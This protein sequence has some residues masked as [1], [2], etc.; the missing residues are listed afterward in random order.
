MRPL[1]RALTVLL[2][3]P[4]LLAAAC[5]EKL[6]ATPYVMRNESA[7]TTYAA[8]DPT[9]RTPEMQVLYVT[10]RTPTPNDKPG[11]RYGHGR[12]DVVAYGVATVEL[13]P[14]PSWEELVDLS[15]RGDRDREYELK[16]SDVEQKGT[17]T[18]VTDLMEVRGDRLAGR[19]GARAQL[20]AEAGAFGAQ[21]SEWLA[22]TDRK[23]VVV[24]IHGFNNTFDDAVIRLAQAWHFTGRQGVPIVY[25]WPA[26]FGGLSGYAYDRESGEFT[27]VHL[28]L[29]IRA[30]A[31][32]PDVQKIHIVSHSRGTDVATTAL[33]E[34]NAE[35]RGMSGLSLMTTLLPPN[36]ENGGVSRAEFP[37]AAEVF[38]IGTLVLAAPDLDVDV[39]RQRFYAENLVGIAE[40]IIVY[41]SR[42]DEALSWANW[43]FSGRNRMGS[44]RVEDIAPAAR[45]LLQE[46]PRMEMINCRV[47]GY[48]T[49]A[50]VFQHPS[51]LSDLIL[52]LRDGKKPGGANGRP[53][54][55]PTGGI[56]E[57]DNSYMLVK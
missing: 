36:G 35:Y 22:R 45:Q 19:F 55:Q 21:L 17:F 43:L 33:R 18:P 37:T 28:K 6:I 51:A 32:C 3:L 50:Y 39:F 47:S 15:T 5:S 34:L 16:V 57:M 54:G 2:M 7:R 1:N 4:V 52:V 29:L 30:I 11:P 40:R 20:D 27:I 10:D 53:L 14:R 48:T 38:K 8:L 12:S 46:L 23:E 42:E 56:W 25:T 49:H 13:D 26:G 9:L 41:F 44:M 31:A 24:F